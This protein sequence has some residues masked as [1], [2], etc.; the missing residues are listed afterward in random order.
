MRGEV[1]AEDSAGI[2][3]AVRILRRS[4]IKENA[5][6]FLSLRTEDDHAGIDFVRLASVAIDIEDAPCVIVVLAHENFVDHGIGN[7]S[8]V[9]GGNSVSDSGESG[10]EVRVGHAAAFAGA[11]EMARATAV[12]GLG[13]IRA[14]RGHDGAAKFFFD[15]IAEESLLARLGNERMGRAACEVSV[16][17]GCSG[18]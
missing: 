17:F 1:M 3:E 12:E 11:A 16:A 5:D 10:I 15:A 14:A 4:G 18:E 13:E 8:A 2:R 6:R 9:A 7:E